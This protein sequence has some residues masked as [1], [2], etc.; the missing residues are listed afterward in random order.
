[1]SIPEH[2]YNPD[3]DYLNAILG[4]LNGSEEEPVL[5]DH[6]YTP[7]QEYL[8]AIY[9]AVKNGGGGG[10]T[11]NYNVLDN[12]PQING[13]TLQGNK[14]TQELGITASGAEVY[15]DYEDAV[16]AINAWAADH[17]GVGDNVYIRTDN[18]PDLWVSAV[19]ETS[20]PYTY[21]TDAAIVSA[22]STVGYVQFGYYKLS[23]L[24]TQKV[25]IPTITVDDAQ[26]QQLDLSTRE[27]VWETADGTQTTVT[28]FVASGATPSAGGESF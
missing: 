15:D 27:E 11:A 8:Y 12:K 2:P 20:V 3:Q 25:S 4:A 26:V 14:T 6:P 19:E 17:R 7:V 5:P 22:L 18:V 24:E 16:T 28:Y 1:M 23:A 10:G 21:T 9:L 13:V